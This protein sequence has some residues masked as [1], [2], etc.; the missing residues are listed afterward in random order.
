M[1]ISRERH[2]AKQSMELMSVAEICIDDH[3]DGNCI[4]NNDE[5]VDF[6]ADS[7]VGFQGKGAGAGTGG[8]VGGGLAAGC[9]S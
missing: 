2:K 8:S 9:R 7:V 6:A 3:E 5:L 1:I 4:G